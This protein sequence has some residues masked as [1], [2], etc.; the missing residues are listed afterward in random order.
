[1]QLDEIT[2]T[3]KMPPLTSLAEFARQLGRTPVTLWRW[4]QDGWL[5]GIVN[6][7][8]KPYIMREGMEKFLRRAQAGEFSKPSHA[9]K[10]VKANVLNESRLTQHAV[11]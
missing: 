10:K 6:I 11:P 8:G 1:M 2:D 9:P 5:D 4:R 7:A 3:A